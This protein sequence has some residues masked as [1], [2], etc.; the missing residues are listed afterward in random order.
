MERDI[1]NAPRGAVYFFHM[2]LPHSPYVYDA[3][4][5]IKQD[6]AEWEDNIDGPPLINTK[7]NLLRR[8]QKYEQQTQ[9]LTN[10]LS[11]F[12]SDLEARHLTQD[13]VIIV[14][15]DHGSRILSTSPDIINLPDVGAQDQLNA[16]ATL[17][18]LKAPKGSTINPSAF[19][20]ISHIFSDFVSHW[21]GADLPR[22]ISGNYVYLVPKESGQTVL[23]LPVAQQ[24]WL[25]AQPLNFKQ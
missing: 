18:A 7:E 19:V 13:A 23:T 8:Y 15:G 24:Q 12:F 22:Q 14:H 5:H 10:R 3:A 2:L 21:F 25:D 4:C 1:I 17:F 20:P 9:C 16:F 6:S 11:Q